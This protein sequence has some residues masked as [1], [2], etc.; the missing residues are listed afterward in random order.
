MK[1]GIPNSTESDLKGE[2]PRNHA[3]PLK[4]GKNLVLPFDL[5]D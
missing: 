5:P 1:A 3:I 2:N 4:K